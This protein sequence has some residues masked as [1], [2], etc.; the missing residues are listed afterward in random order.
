V[1]WE[2]L[3]TVPRRAVENDD[4]AATLAAVVGGDRASLARLDDRHARL[5]LALAMRILGDRN[6]AEDL[7]HAVFL[8]AW[9]H[10]GDFDPRGAAC[11]PG[12]SPACARARW[13]AAPPPADRRAW[14]RDPSRR[15]RAG[16][17]EGAAALDGARVRR[18]VAGLPAI[19]PRS[20]TWPTSTGCRRRRLRSARHPHRTVKSRMARAIAA[21][22]AGL[23][24]SLGG[25]A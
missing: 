9:H 21:L 16:A 11:A 23:E 19:W 1:Q 18:Q 12:W 20:S 13:I 2:E 7:L 3:R 25:S 15:P 14:R 4:D 22:R 17:P 6:Q 8:E 10:A 5:L 24:P